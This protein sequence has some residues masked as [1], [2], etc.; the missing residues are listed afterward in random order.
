MLSRLIV[1]IVIVGASGLVSAQVPVSVQIPADERSQVQAFESSLRTAIARAGSQLAKRARE[2]APNI[3][4]RFEAEARI[5]SLVLP[6]E[7]L[8]FLVDVPGI[9]PRNLQQWELSRLLSGRP[10]PGSAGSNV[11]NSGGRV[12]AT[13]VAPDPDSV[14]MTDPVK[15]YSD[16]T[17]DAIVDAML[18]SAF[19][20]PVREG[21]KLTV[22]VGDGTVGLPANPLAEPSRMLYLRLKGEDIIALR[23]NR[24]TRDE[25]KKRILQWVY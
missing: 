19:A 20:L 16:F 11:A 22:I 4:L 18:D 1:A 21:E 3:E 24:I 5:V 7:G 9:L 10:N 17:H 8:Q 12:T 23:Q 13:I 15:E 14:L 2:V 6:D 25:A